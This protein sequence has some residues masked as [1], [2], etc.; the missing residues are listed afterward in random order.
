M[1]D[2]SANHIQE[3]LMSEDATEDGYIAILKEYNVSMF[4]GTCMAANIEFIN[5]RVVK[6]MKALATEY[7]KG[8]YRKGTD[9]V[10]YIEHPKQVVAR[11]K[12][13]GI[14]FGRFHAIAWGHDLLEDTAVTE[15]EI[16]RIAGETILDRIK[17]LTKKAGEDKDAYIEKIA[18]EAPEEC[19][20]IKIADR[21][22]N[23][24]DFLKYDSQ[25]AY[26]YYKEGRSLYN[27]IPRIKYVSWREMIESDVKR[28]GERL[29]EVQ[30]RI[31]DLWD[32]AFDNMSWA[33]END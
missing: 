21:L 17:W 30:E 13:W 18:Y 5:E 14:G 1:N 24:L 22:C 27:N 25:R 26:G 20:I 10:P 3:Y 23:S 9:K 8:Q 19:L 7:H 33:E 6:K 12:S 29:R 31:D 16:R 4:D 28:V 2:R 11:L 32:R 15:D